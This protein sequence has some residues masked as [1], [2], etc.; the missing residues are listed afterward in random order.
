MRA[1]ACER[2]TAMSASKGSRPLRF[3]FEAM[4][5]GLPD[6]A[7]ERKLPDRVFRV[8]VGS[9]RGCMRDARPGRGCCCAGKGGFGYSSRGSCIGRRAG[10]SVLLGLELACASARPT[11]RRAGAAARPAPTR[12]KASRREV[13]CLESSGF[14][15]IVSAMAVPR[16]PACTVLRARQRA[17]ASLGASGIRIA[18]ATKRRVGRRARTFFRGTEA[19]NKNSVI[20]AYESFDRRQPG[21]VT[22]E[23]KAA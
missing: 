12:C 16:W 20:E 21:W 7:T 23:L 14:M 1:R 22:V 17:D 9:G 6:T 18:V 13:G 10:A 4:T 3:E 8:I 5:R 15:A 2:F 11:A 19:M